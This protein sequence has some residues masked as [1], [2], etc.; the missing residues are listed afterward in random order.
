MERIL[1]RNQF[2]VFSGIAAIL[3]AVTASSPANPDI[4][5][6]TLGRRQTDDQP[7]VAHIDARQFEHI[8]KE[9]TN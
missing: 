8:A 2:A 6:G 4:K 9:S 3:L 5:S 7:P 1:V